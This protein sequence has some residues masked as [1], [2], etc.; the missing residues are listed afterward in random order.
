M[1]DPLGAAG[2]LIRPEDRARVGKPVW[3]VSG[4]VCR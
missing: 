4:I 1:T 2:A 3:D